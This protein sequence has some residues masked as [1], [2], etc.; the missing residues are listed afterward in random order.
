M[1]R[2]KHETEELGVF[3]KAFDALYPAIRYTYESLRHHEWFTEV[4]PQLWL[5]GAPDFE[6]D[7]QYIR[8]RGIG[9][10]V[11]IRSEREDDTAFYEAHDIRH[12]RY[13]VPDVEVP[14]EAVISDA[15]RWID[16]QVRSG[17]KVL[18]HCAKGRGRSAT[19]VA[20]Y[21]IQSQGLTFDQ[22][23]ELLKAKRPL[24]KLEDRHR[25][26]LETWAAAS[27]PATAGADR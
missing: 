2:E 26:R 18:V 1:A 6:R 3:H 22:A 21:L 19:L 12:Q 8:D 11:N 17:R 14:S 25:T 7:Y 5:G 13:C 20:A 9:A 24:T 4:T 15:V 23:R 16:A 27:Q 10:V